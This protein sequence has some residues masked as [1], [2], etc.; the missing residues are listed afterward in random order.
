MNDA[1]RAGAY[2]AAGLVI[3]A[4]AAGLARRLLDRPHRR[5]ALRQA[6]RP[7]AALLFWLIL[8]AGL[9]A[10]VAS[11][12]PETLDP[13][14]SDILAWLPRVGVAGLILIA[15][16]VLATVTTAAVARTA[17]RATGRR[18]PVAESITRITVI[19]AA[20]ILA[21]TQLGIDTTIL[22]IVVAAVAFGIA[23]AAAGIAIVGG[24]HTAH[25][26]AAGRSLAEHLEIG[27][28]IRVGE[29]AGVLDQ[30]TATHLVVVDDRSHRV[31]IP[32]CL[33]DTTPI[34]AEATDP[35]KTVGVD[36]SDTA[37]G[38][39]RAKSDAHTRPTTAAPRSGD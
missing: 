1:W 24:R 30:V 19:G 3:G 20:A 31:I 23:G 26:V 10:A 37:G 6:A 29:H 38:E 21:L 16:Y 11:T 28:R 22:N 4:V 2:I 13:I 34:V 14:P 8:A 27:E 32:F 39:A 33:T 12:S 17:S 5:D 36:R 25:S 9:V 18:H 35:S 15:G 7:T